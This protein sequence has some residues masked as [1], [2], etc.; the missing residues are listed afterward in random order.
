MLIQITRSGTVVE[1][2]SADLDRL[3]AGFDRDHCILLRRFIEP[4]LLDMLRAAVEAASFYEKTN[5]NIGDELRI[6]PH[7]VSTAF[8]FL[9][10]DPAV[11]DVARRITGCPAVGCFRGRVYRLLPT[12]GHESGWHTDLVHGR[13][14]TMSI[15]LSS[16]MFEGGLLQIRDANT[17]RV[18]TEVANTGPGDAVLFRIDPSLQHRV[19]PLVGAVPRTAYAGWFLQEPQFAALLRGRLNAAVL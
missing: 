18:F 12:T 5:R 8:E 16:G 1:A 17:G 19:T 11:Y 14:L 3:R 15:N 6:R 2:G 10:N 7:P 13:M 4:S 9:T